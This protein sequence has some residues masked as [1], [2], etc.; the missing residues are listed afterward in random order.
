MNDINPTYTFITPKTYNIRLKVKDN[1]GCEGSCSNE[2]IVKDTA[3]KNEI[4]YI[5]S[6]CSNNGTPSCGYDKHFIIQNDTLKIYGFIGGNCCSQKTAT[7]NYRKDTVY[8][9]TFEVGSLCACSC[10]FC[11]AINVPNIKKDSIRVSFNGSSFQATR[12]ITTIKLNPY[13]NK[14]KIYPNPVK[15]SFTID[16]SDLNQNNYQIQIYNSFGQIVYFDRI[17]NSVSQS[18]NVEKFKSGIYL[19]RTISDKSNIYINKIII[20]NAR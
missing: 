8:I 2:I 5:V 13:V 9:K 17:V 16:Y 15:N 12:T 10:G 20:N 1:F 18:I 6:S 11:F 7:V 19:I 3:Q 4:N 14:I